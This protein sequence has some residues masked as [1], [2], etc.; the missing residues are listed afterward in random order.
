[1]LTIYALRWSGIITVRGRSGR[2]R[3][4]LDAFVG[5]RRGWEGS[6]CDGVSA[7][8]RRSLLRRWRA[9]RS[10][11][12]HGQRTE[13]V[14]LR[15]GRPPPQGCFNDVLRPGA[16]PRQW[17]VWALC[18]LLCWSAAWHRSSSASTT[19][20]TTTNQ[21][22]PVGGPGEPQHFDCRERTSGLYP[23]SDSTLLAY[24]RTTS[25]TAPTFP[26]SEHCT[27]TV[28]HGRAPTPI[29]GSSSQLSA[30]STAVAIVAPTALYPLR[31]LTRD[32]A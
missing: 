14:F 25:N 2:R 5:A 23:R 12:V 21:S 29:S 30:G 1:M 19:C 27:K 10:Q 15:K 17:A 7:S 28:D 22:L 6:R 18:I 9:N 8:R 4:C 24:N 16:R 3:I 13:A 20:R 31:L 32:T 26:P 11:K